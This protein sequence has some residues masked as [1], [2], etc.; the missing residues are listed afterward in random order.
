MDAEPG[1]KPRDLLS[2][3]LAALP[4]FGGGQGDEGQS[5]DALGAGWQDRV[6]L[7]RPTATNWRAPAAYTQIYSVPVA[8][9][10]ASSSRDKHSYQA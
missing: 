7:P 5:L 1:A 8:G 10:E 3:R 4:G 2:T 9:G 6:F